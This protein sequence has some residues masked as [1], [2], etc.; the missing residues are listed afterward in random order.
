MSDDKKTED[1]VPHVG[2]EF[3]P[4][5]PVEDFLD[6]V[7]AVI[8]PTFYAAKVGAR[9]AAAWA[10]HDPCEDCGHGRL[11]HKRQSYQSQPHRNF[12]EA[13]SETQCRQNAGGPSACLCP[14]WR[15]T[16]TPM[17]EAPEFKP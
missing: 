13:M 12:D 11:L 4:P 7:D 8:S 10:K 14:A 5:I 15:G 2:V 3:D 16:E 9:Y 17:P 1:A 6:A